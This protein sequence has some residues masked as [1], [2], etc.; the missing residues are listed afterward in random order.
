[1]EAEPTKAVLIELTV[2][3]A[4]IAEAVY[5]FLQQL[6]MGDGNHSCLIAMFSQTN[7]QFIDKSVHNRRKHVRFNKSLVGWTK[8]YPQNPKPFSLV[9]RCLARVSKTYAFCLDFHAYRT[10]NVA[11]TTAEISIRVA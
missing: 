11:A 5:L 8:L 1:L 10:I 6:Q 7:K 3:Q 2:E 9:S 4:V